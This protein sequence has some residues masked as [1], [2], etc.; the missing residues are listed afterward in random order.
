VGYICQ[1]RHRVTC[2]DDEYL[3]GH[4]HALGVHFSTPLFFFNLIQKTRV[5]TL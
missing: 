3:Q 4:H 2:L 5:Q 1:L